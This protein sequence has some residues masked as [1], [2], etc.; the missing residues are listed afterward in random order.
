MEKLRPVGSGMLKVSW[1]EQPSRSKVDSENQLKQRTINI[2][3]VEESLKDI[4]QF[5]SFLLV[6]FCS[7]NGP[8]KFTL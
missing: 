2:H 5:A 1:N 3:T 8:A 4:R 6:S 7:T